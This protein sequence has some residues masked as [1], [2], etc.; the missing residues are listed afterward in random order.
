M[1][2]FEYT[3]YI[4]DNLTDS[5]IPLFK[6]KN[7]QNSKIIYEFES[8]IPESISDELIRSQIN[9]KC[10]LTPYVGTIGNIGIHNQEG[11]FHL[12]SNV[13]KIELYPYDI[14]IEEFLVHYL[15]SNYGY[16][17]LTKYKKATCQDSISIDAIR[18]V[19]VPIPP[20]N[21]QHRIV[22]KIDYLFNM[23]KD[24]D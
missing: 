14:I 23:L 21:E 4:A 11:K 19:Y 2:G 5:G 18:E 10:I 6:G 7:I 9:K 1:A 22:K 8:W 20:L 16:S 24:E 13:G 17:E 15:K 12:G 3:K